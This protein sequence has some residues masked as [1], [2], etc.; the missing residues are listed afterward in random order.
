MGRS[1]KGQKKGRT[2][3]SAVTNL[4]PTIRV[5]R[6]PDHGDLVD[7]LVHVFVDDQNLFFGIVNHQYG[8][9]FRID[10]GR[11]LLEVAKG[12]DGRTR[13]V[14]SAYIAGVIPDDDTFWEV[15]RNR[16]FEVR[17][18]YLGRSGKRNRS[19]MDDAYLIT[20]M[21]KTLYEKPGLSTMVL[22]AGDA[23][24]MPPLELAVEKGWRTE[25]V[26]MDRGIASALEPK[27][28]EFRLLVPT[29]IEHI[30]MVA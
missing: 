14:S 15:A 5:G 22:V 25:V 17:R 21:T 24:Y 10:F 3:H 11:L 20:D 27:V 2:R 7:D 12:S 4:K 9:G 23:D 1:R 6:A 8:R 28:H 19:K 26:F 16:G 30:P 29:A 18:G 13:A